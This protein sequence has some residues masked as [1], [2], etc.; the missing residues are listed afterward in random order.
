MEEQSAKL[1]QVLE[2]ALPVLSIKH[3]YLPHMEINYALSTFI[4]DANHIREIQDGLM[5]FLLIKI[6]MKPT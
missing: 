5:Y 6:K 2:L 4:L 1:L 3:F